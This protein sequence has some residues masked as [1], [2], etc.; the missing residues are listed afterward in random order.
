MN[1]DIVRYHQ[2]ELTVAIVIDECAA[3]APVRFGPLQ[4]LALGLIAKRTLAGIVQE[5]VMSPLTDKQINK[6][7]VIEIARAHSLSPSS[8]ANT[9][10][11]RHILKR[12]PP[13]LWYRCTVSRRQA[14]LSGRLEQKMS[15]RPSLS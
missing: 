5:Y 10:L 8:V 1:V 4:T 14:G 9:R 13:K 15:G 11:F 6:T 7:I 2:V 12:S 3:R